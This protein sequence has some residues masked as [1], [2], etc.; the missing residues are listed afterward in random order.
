MYPLKDYVRYPIP[1]FPTK[2][3]P[4]LLPRPR[5]E[6]HAETRNEDS[7]EVLAA[8]L[9][10]TLWEPRL[11]QSFFLGIVVRRSW[12]SREPPKNSTGLDGQKGGGGVGGEHG[13]ED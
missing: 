7:A 4:I 3:Q 13:V 2:N 5:S 1:S 6:I 12:I 9:G 8:K 10:S 11:A